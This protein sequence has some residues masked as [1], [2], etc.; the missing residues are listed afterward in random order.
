MNLHLKNI[1]FIWEQSTGGG[2]EEA[3][4]TSTLVW[5]N[6]MRSSASLLAHKIH[7]SAI[8]QL[9]LDDEGIGVIDCPEYHWDMKHHASLQTV[10]DLTDTLI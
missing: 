7:A 10:Q 3:V 6:G 5:G 4:E 1:Y 8:R 2:S 9:F